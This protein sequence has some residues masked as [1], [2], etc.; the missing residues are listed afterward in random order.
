MVPVS[1]YLCDWTRR[2]PERSRRKSFWDVAFQEISRFD[3]LPAFEMEKLSVFEKSPD[4]WTYPEIHYCFSNIWYR[5]L[6]ND[7]LCGK[8][9][10]LLY[11]KGREASDRELLTRLPGW[12]AC[13]VAN[14]LEEDVD[15]SRTELNHAAITRRVFRKT[16]TPH[17]WSLTGKRYW[18]GAVSFYKVISPLP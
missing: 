18:N 3:Q 15:L 13:R 10:S 9:E 12:R 14:G 6:G 11:R 4:N 7:D 17:G 16:V 5:L 1:V 2:S 8:T